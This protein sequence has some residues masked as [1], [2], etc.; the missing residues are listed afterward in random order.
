MNGIVVGPWPPPPGT[1]I[2]PQST[3]VL[4][5]GSTA[6][7][8]STPV[9]CPGN[10]RPGCIVITVTG[11]LLVMIV[12]V[13]TGAFE[14]VSVA[15]RNELIEEARTEEAR[16]GEGGSLAELDGDDVKAVGQ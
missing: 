8:L 2:G 7:V 6:T 9:V 12:V 15:T 11:C 10:E 5:A 4:V 16:V 1:E 13:P 14:A 3:G